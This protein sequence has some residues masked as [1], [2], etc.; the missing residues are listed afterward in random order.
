MWMA[1]AIV[2]ASARL[3]PLSF[4]LSLFAFV[5]MTGYP[6]ENHHG[7]CRGRAGGQD[8]GQGESRCQP[9]QPRRGI[10]AA[11]KSSADESSPFLLCA[12]RR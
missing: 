7:S 8:G 3:L 9:R 1:C 10:S 11:R 6:A 5:S 4:H 12:R 2:K